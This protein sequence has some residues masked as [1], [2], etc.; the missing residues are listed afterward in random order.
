MTSCEEAL[1]YLKVCGR[2]RLD[3]DKDG[4]P[5]ENT[6]CRNYRPAKGR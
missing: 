6:V 1:Y 4:V 5:C 2:K 3:A